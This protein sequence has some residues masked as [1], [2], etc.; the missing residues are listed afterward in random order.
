MTFVKNSG[1]SV[2]SNNS[3][4]TLGVGV[5]CGGLDVSA[6]GTRDFLFFSSCSKHSSSVFDVCFS[7]S[8][9]EISTLGGG[10]G[11]LAEGSRVTLG[12]WLGDQRPDA[13]L[14]GLCPDATIKL[15]LGEG[16]PSC[17]PRPTGINHR[18]IG[19]TMHDVE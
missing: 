2:F 5:S 4:T 6:N 18:S 11:G 19:S 13:K 12:S 7:A 17:H 3:T 9:L 16:I 1:F 15:Y 14:R 8:G 10:A